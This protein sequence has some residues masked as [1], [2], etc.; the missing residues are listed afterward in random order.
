MQALLQSLPVT[1][2]LPGFSNLWLRILRVLQVGSPT[3]FV[4][5]DVAL[6]PLL[7]S[8]QRPKFL[9]TCGAV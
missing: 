9:H 2:S 1:S 5:P 3:A 8:W 6:L 4:K 7:L